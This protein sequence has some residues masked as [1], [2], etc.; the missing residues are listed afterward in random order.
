MKK[1]STY[2]FQT[3]SSGTNA[4]ATVCCPG[5]VPG[6]YRQPCCPCPQE[7]SP[8][9][10]APSAP[11]QSPCR[12]I[13][14]SCHILTIFALSSSAMRS[15]SMLLASSVHLKLSLGDLKFANAVQRLLLWQTNDQ[16]AGPLYCR[17]ASPCVRLHAVRGLITNMHAVRGLITNMH[18]VRGLITNAAC[19][20]NLKLMA[21]PYCPRPAEDY[22]RAPLQLW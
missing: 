21:V 8:L 17:P 10:Q 5:T 16:L 11:T 12:Q 13:L 15:L 19:C 14:P 20:L 22:A 18:A 1:G 6:G 4:S 3:C 9:D 7:P 2:C